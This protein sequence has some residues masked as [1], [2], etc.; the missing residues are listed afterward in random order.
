MLFD[1]TIAQLPQCYYLTFDFFA[2]D[3]PQ[4]MFTAPLA[5]SL[6]GIKASVSL[7]FLVTKN[8][9]PRHT[10]HQKSRHNHGMGPRGESEKGE[11]EWGTEPSVQ[12]IFYILSSE[13]RIPRILL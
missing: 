12:S 13:D 9:R 5:G 10:S 2:V 4:I 7:Q 3:G 11:I 8:Q 1:F 6:I